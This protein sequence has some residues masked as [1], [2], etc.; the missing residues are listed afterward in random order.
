MNLHQKVIKHL[1]EHKDYN[2][3]EMM[4][5]LNEC[6]ITEKEEFLLDVI[7]ATEAVLK[8]EKQNVTT[9]TYL[10]ESKL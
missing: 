4:Q 10:P 7:Y 8:Q 9:S 2:I 1:I 5:L 6:N 3:N